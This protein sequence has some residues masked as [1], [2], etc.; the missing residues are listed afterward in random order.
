MQR[1]VNEDNGRTYDNAVSAMGKYLIYQS[2]NDANSLNMSKQFIKLLPLKY[3]LD[4]CKVI[5]EEVFT[6]IKNNKPLIVNDNNMPEIKQ[7]II[8]IK[9]LNDEKKFLEEQED[10][11]K[12]IA[13]KLGL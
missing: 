1:E 5:C 13:S 10:N 8:D 4:E 12:E 3:D 11:L 6:Q 2:N 7:S 9:K